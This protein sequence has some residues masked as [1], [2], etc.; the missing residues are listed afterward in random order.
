MIFRRLYHD[1]LAQASYLIACE[2]TRQAF[3]VDPVRD[4]EPYLMAAASED[5]RIAFVAE[6]HIHA[7]FLS[8]AEALAEASGAELLLS[9]EGGDDAAHARV[10]RTGARPLHDGDTIDVGRI[11][12]GVRHTPG[13]TPEHVMFVVTDRAT[14][15]LPVGA[16]TGD[17]LFA[18]DVGR[19]DLLERA[20]GVQGSMR[21]SARQLFRSLQSMRALPEYLQVWPGHGAGS[22]CG[23][24]LGAVPQSTL[25]YELHS[26]WAFLERDEDAF[27]EQALRDQPDP[28]AYFARMKVAN[29]HGVP[30]MPAIAPLDEAALLA[31]VRGG[32]RVVDMRAS[33]DF[34]RGHLRGS[35]SVPL[36]RTFLHWVGSLIDPGRDVVLV[37]EAPARHAAREAM[38]DLALI[39]FDR[40]LG[41]I[42]PSAFASLAPHGLES[43]PII[44]GAELAARSDGR[45]ILDVRN[46]SEWEAGHIPGAIHVPL[47]RLP[48]HVS[49][50]RNAGPLAIHCQGGARSAIAVS[51]LRAEGI[52]DV[53]DVEGGYP[54]WLRAANGAGREGS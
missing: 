42:E 25:G 8:G 52:D 1:R 50:L 12:L 21:R 36:S 53:T 13:H 17:F 45:T 22:A 27:V 14:S 26:N 37:A 23:K 35:V 48:A 44:S 6:T 18:G 43:V 46:D 49:E 54:A 39:G 28:P 5:V 10:Q 41:A 33:G 24:S 51:V 34:L 40:V 38:H 3:V 15:S 29:A 9:V 20:V 19:P 2:A 16:L 32:A 30:P 31:A 7:D 4:L 11:A 47:S